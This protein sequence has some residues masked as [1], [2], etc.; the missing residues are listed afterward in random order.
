MITAYRSGTIRNQHR[1]EYDNDLKAG[2]LADC[3]KCPHRDCST[4]YNFIVPNLKLL[5]FV[6]NKAI[7]NAGYE[8]PQHSE[9]S[10]LVP[11]S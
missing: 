5:E 9:T 4:E 3:I 8:H 1:D 2:G 11:E 7:E 6:R 10:I